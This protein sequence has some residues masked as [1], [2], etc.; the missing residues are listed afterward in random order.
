M[1]TRLPVLP[2]IATPTEGQAVGKQ[3][4][5]TKRKRTPRGTGETKKRTKAPRYEGLMNSQLYGMEKV[6]WRLEGKTRRA[7]DGPRTK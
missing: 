3:A 5:S 2:P 6:H 7:I 1:Q 4:S